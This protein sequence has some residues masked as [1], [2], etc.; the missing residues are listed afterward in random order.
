[1]NNLSF[2]PSSDD[3]RDWIIESHY[4]GHLKKNWNQSRKEIKVPD[5]LSYLG[6]LSDANTAVAIIREWIEWRDSQA[7]VKF[8]PIIEKDQTNFNARDVLRT[9]QKKGIL[10]EKDKGKYDSKTETVRAEP[11]QIKNYIRIYSI[12]GLKRSLSDNGPALIILPVFTKIDDNE[13]WYPN[14]KRIGGTDLVV[15]GY[16]KKG[17]LLIAPGHDKKII[18]FPYSDWGFQWEVWAVMNQHQK[19][20]EQKK[21]DTEKLEASLKQKSESSSKRKRFLRKLKIKKNKVH[22]DPPRKKYSTENLQNLSL[23]VE[24]ISDS[25]SESGWI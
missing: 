22:P 5:F 10:I 8:T 24:E 18:H 13:F 16:D 7:S 23:T 1:M 20:I 25:D 15:V 11:F 17:F 6:E 2:I 9:M 4:Q 14:G 12:D 3:D 21:R 19:T